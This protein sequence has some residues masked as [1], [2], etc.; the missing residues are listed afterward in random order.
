MRKVLA[1]A[2]VVAAAALAVGCI[3]TKQ[4]FTLNPDGSGKVLVEMTMPQMPFNLGPPDGQ[5]D[6]DLA[7]KQFVKQVLDGSKGVDAWSDVQ[8]AK[9]EDGRT[10]F[11]GTAYFKDLSQMKLQ[12]GKMEGISFTKDDRGGMVLS[13]KEQES[14]K[15][16]T[17]P[18]EI[19]EGQ[20]A[21]RIQAERMQY[22]Q[23]RPMMATMLGT[24]K[25]DVSFRLPGTLAEVSGFKKE[26][27]GAV[28]LAFDGAQM[29]KALDELMADDA[30]VRQSVLA[31]KKSGGG[32]PQMD[33]QTREK[34]FGTKG[35][36]RARVTG[37][38]KTLFPYESEV[39]AAKAAY[40]AMIKRLGLDKLPAA[41]PTPTLPPGFGAPQGGGLKG[42]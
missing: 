11:I 37:P 33:Q 9:T 30:Y 28:R 21:Q 13:I 31:G 42:R 17:P 39:A 19:P 29:L 35:P 10:R 32:S 16:P 27:S 24:M 38:F 36:L 23:M 7:A 8:Y 5:G 25:M 18:K 34:L 14:A 2:A 1:V 41:P 40:P 22:Q 20:M 26:P 15:P 6:P 4:D 12:S 3:E